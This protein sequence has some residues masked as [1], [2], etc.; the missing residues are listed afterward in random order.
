M[1]DLIF[2]PATGHGGAITIIRL[3]GFLLPDALITLAGPLPKPREAALRRFRTAQAQT[4]DQGLLL[5]F[6]APHSVTGEN[7]AELHLHGGRAVRAAIADALVTIGARPAEPGE[8]SRRAFANGKIDL[9]QAE[10]IADLIDAETEAQRRMALEQSGGETSRAV[11]QWRTTLINAMAQLAATI[12]FADEDLPPE[13]EF[14]LLQS[15]R[16]LRDELSAALGATHAA[17]RLREGLSVVILGPPN[18]GKSSLLNAIAGS[19]IAIVAP[20]PGTTRDAIA[21]RLIIAGIPLQLTDT[22][23]LR[24]TADPIEAEGVRRAQRHAHEA[25]LI[26]ALHPAPDFP[27]PPFFS[28]AIP[29]LH[30][31]SK[32]DLATGEIPAPLLPISTTTNTGLDTLLDRLTAELSRLTD[33]QGAPALARPRHA[34]CLRDMIAALDRALTTQDAE[35]RAQDLHTCAT[36]LARLTGTIGVEDIL[37]QVFCS[38]CIG[39]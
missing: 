25:D 11:Q 20:T 3:T 5:W 24:D 19:D 28:A 17:E 13:T 1:T 9:L 38:F 15:I 6:P 35:L 32:A 23:G 8:F 7:Y 33:R 10:G 2:A 39:K 22:A 27:T 16:S 34:A 14:S 31:A 21:T 37:D 36:A 18:A 29:T 30:I 12:D 4:I 26:L